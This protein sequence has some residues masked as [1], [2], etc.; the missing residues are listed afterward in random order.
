MGEGARQDATE[1]RT[2]RYSCSSYQRHHANIPPLFANGVSAAAA[3]DAPLY[4]PLPLPP[5]SCLTVVAV[6]TSSSASRSVSAISFS[7]SSD[8]RLWCG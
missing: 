7:A 8:W 2:R 4:P 1:E 6:L 3:P 5:P